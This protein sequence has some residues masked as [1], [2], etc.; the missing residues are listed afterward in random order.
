M[1]ATTPEERRRGVFRRF[2]ESLSKS[3]KALT[4]ELS[5]SF[6]ER[7]D[8]ETWER[9]EEALILADLLVT[10]N[11]GHIEQI[12]TYEEIYDQPA[13]IFVAGFLNRHVGTPPISF[14]DAEQLVP[15]QM[16]AHAQIGVRPEDVEVSG[17]PQPGRLE[18]RIVGKLALP[19]LNAAILSIQ[20][21]EHEIYAQQSIDA[22]VP[23]GARVWLTLKRYHV[24]DR[25]TGKRGRTVA[26]RG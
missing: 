9:L 17:E 12:G 14:L 6:F 10:M 13:N 19:M 20:V 3:R 2:R 21:G 8:E 7:I 11:R 4:E 23:A 16:S 18:G 15:E 26:R 22:S 5:S 24:F 25:A 1:K